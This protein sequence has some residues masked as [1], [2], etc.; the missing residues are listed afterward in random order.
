MADS[1]PAAGA[2]I[3]DG[4][5][6]AMTLRAEAATVIAALRTRH[7]VL[8]GL[9][10]VIVG[11]DPASRGYLTMILKT[12][13]AVDLPVQLIELPATASRGL[14]QA[15]IARL[16][17]LPEIAG[18]IV[19][20]PLPPP[21]GP[22]TV[23]EVLDPAKDIDG[24]HPENAGRLAL[25]YAGLDYFV[26]P[27]PQAG[28]ALLRQHNISLAGKSAVVLGR[29]PVVGRPLTLLLLAANATVT[30]AHSYTPPAVLRQQIAAADVVASAVGKPGLVRGEML[31]PGAVVLD[32]GVSVVDGVM[33]GD[34]DF[35]AARAVAAAITPV[36][37]GI[38]PVT[39]LMLVRNT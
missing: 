4:R 39:T 24:I 28:L 37:G 20:M 33:R 17:V 31:K 11:A 19:Q 2:V 32:F 7:P 15:E 12:C 23:S 5:A 10:V 14:I 29:S 27:T 21:L 16:N 38:G 6:L 13:A 9:A 25:G 34:V 22:E 1:T 8:P 26:P 3:L 30:A 18:V 36:P 35:A